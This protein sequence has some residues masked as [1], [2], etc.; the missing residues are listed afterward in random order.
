LGRSLRFVAAIALASLGVCVC[1]CAKTD[2][3]PAEVPATSTD[4][5]GPVLGKQAAFAYESLDDRP[6]TSAATAGAPRLLVFFTVGDV[7]SQAQV[8]YVDVMAKRDAKPSDAGAAGAAAGTSAGSG[9]RAFYAA[10]ALEPQES[11]E[12]VDIYQHSLKL[13]IPVA[14][15]DAETLRGGGAFGTFE[16]VPTVVVLDGAGR[17]VLRRTGLT[18][19]DELRAVLSDL[20]VK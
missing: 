20:G 1:G 19:P 7:M 3:P 16:G 11:R 2:A 14:L 10:V 8:R 18:K 12:L 17:I 5:S 15:A 4:T 6:V 13:S 9:V